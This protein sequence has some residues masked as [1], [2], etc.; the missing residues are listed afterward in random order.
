MRFTS[1]PMAFIALGAA[2]LASQ[3]YGQASAQPLKATLS[4]PAEKPAGDPQGSGTASFQVDPA[5]GEVCYTLQVSK[6]APATMAHI[7]KA[8]PGAAGPV[9]VPLAAPDASGKSAGCAKADAAVLTAIQE[10]PSDYY[11][12]VHNAAFPGGAVRG[13]LTK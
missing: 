3:A 7:H 2:A 6:I 10:T 12:N 5:K 4:G 13:Q 8:P 1:I 9:V 11:V